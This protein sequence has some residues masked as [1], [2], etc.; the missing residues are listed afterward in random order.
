MAREDE[1]IAIV[2][3]RKKVEVNELAELLNV[4][5]VT[6]RKDLDRLEE[7]GMI[8]RQH[9]FAEINNQGDLN[10]RLATNYE[11]KKKI[12]MRARDIVNDGETIIIESGS[13]CVLLA[14]EIAMHCKDVTIITNSC[15]LAAYVRKYDN[16]E[17]ILLG[18]EYQKDSQVNVGPLIKT[19]IDHFYVDKLFVGIDGY[20][21]KGIF[22]GS[23]LARADAS[24]LMA[25][26]ANKVIILTDSSKFIQRG[27][28][29][30]FNVSEI[31]TIFTDEGIDLQISR[32]LE[33]YGLNLIKV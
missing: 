4:S 17:I 10:Y 3:Q 33:Q 22:T 27:L 32:Q 21:P 1:I 31:D 8:H 16:I 5:K 23:D 13:T 29:T 25:Q 11:L 12:A 15:F 7:R 6:I 19:V 18:G 28:V 14:E 30:E 24:K 20:N 26:S 9:G 2:N